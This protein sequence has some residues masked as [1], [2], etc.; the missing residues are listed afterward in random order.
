MSEGLFDGFDADQVQAIA[1]QLELDKMQDG[2]ARAH[3]TPANRLHVRRCNAEKQLAEILPARFDAGDTWDVISTGN[4]DA[5]SYLRHALAGVSHFDRVLMSTWRVARAD[6]EEIRGWIDEGRIDQFELYA[7]EGL[8][9]QC[10]DAH[11][12]LQAMVVMYGCTLVIARNHSKVTLAE[13]VAEGYRL[14]IRSSANVN[15]NPRIEQTT[16]TCSDDLHAFYLEFFTGV[17]SIERG[18]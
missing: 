18:A 6:I 3:R 9:T 15:T 16:I 2:E 5:L 10:G 7:G 13:N 17:R 4:V 11:E 12:L 14:A 1:A 8:Q